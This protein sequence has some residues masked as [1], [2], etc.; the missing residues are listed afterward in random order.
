MTTKSSDNGKRLAMKIV[1]V[2]YSLEVGGAET[3]VA[4]LCQLQRAKGHEVSVC[5]Y[6]ALGPLGEMLR[7]EG[8]EVYVPGEANP[9]KTMWRYFQHFRQV[10][11]DV[12]HCHNPAPTIQAAMSARLAGA[13]C[14]VSTRHS[15]VA[16]PYDVVEERKYGL[17]ASFCDAIVGICEVTCG[18]LRRAPFAHTKKIV[19]V[20][21]G[22][23]A[24]EPSDFHT[25][26][27]QGF[28]M[29]FVGRV[30]AIKDLGTMI[31]AVAIAAEKVLGL[32]LW[33]V[34]DG[35]VRAELEALAR[36]L[37]V[38]KRVRF[39]GQRMDTAQFFS[40]ADVFVMSSVSEGLPMSLLQA[41]SLGKPSIVTDVGG[42][43]EVVRLSGGGLLTPVGDAGKYAQA[44]VRM[45]YDSG[46][47]EELGGFSR[48]SYQDEFTLA[49]M[50][51]RY[52]EIY[53]RGRKAGGIS[54]G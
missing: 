14:V 15:L 26:G 10:K 34:G 46:L 16:P 12:V 29:V 11:P 4:Q 35:P 22:S 5:A 19:R 23:L 13:K 50:E 6:S 24:S 37:G 53:K 3:L 36:E 17:M 30:A 7:A 41:M 42:M 44:I 54:F 8:V 18:N 48:R 43:A 49:K 1:H 52:M 27:K 2:V 45:A 31:R 51:M 21:N 39:W 9:L 32:E 38:S 47:R 20:Y 28:T 25:L 33:I 40:A